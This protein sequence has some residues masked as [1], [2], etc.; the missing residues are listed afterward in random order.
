LANITPLPLEAST[1]ADDVK[2]LIDL[3]KQLSNNQKAKQ[4]P[5][6]IRGL[7]YWRDSTKRTV[8]PVEQENVVVEL[9]KEKKVEDS[10]VVS[11]VVVAPKTDAAKPL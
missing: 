11:S 3:G 7:S 10:F 5:L 9:P 8:A 1:E 4:V 2:A 6:R